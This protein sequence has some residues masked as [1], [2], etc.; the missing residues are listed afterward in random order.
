VA[1]RA[2][3]KESLYTSF[4][5]AFPGPGLLCDPMI[6]YA[7]VAHAEILA[8]YPYSAIAQVQHL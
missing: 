3:L 1:L 4:R 6:L 8:L 7:E 5:R 2:I